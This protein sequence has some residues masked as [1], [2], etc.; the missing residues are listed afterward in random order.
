MHVALYTATL[1]AIILTA[2][3]GKENVIFTTEQI[4]WAW[5]LL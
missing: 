1:Q 4:K 5:T 2:L 3:L